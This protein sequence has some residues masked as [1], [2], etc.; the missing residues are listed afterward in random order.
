MP[1]AAGLIFGVLL[2]GL[3]L[4]SGQPLASSLAS[5][6]GAFSGIAAIAVAIDKMLLGA[7][8]T[9]EDADGI[10]QVVAYKEIR[11]MVPLAGAAATAVYL[12]VRFVSVSQL[13]TVAVNLVLLGALA[14]AIRLG[15]NRILKRGTAS[16]QV[17]D[18]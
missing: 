7:A 12:W 9:A 11:A 1:L 13:W 4:K 16:S 14:F 3:Q 6:L 2:A 8:V 5:A 17:A 18:A 10:A 15:A